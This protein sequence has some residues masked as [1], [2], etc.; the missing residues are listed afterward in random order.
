MLF[1]LLTTLLSTSPASQSFA[2]EN[3]T[4]EVGDGTTL[5]R[6]TVWVDQGRIRAVGETVQIPASV[7]RVDGRGQVLTPGLFETQTQLGLFEVEAEDSTVDHQYA[8]DHITPD[9]RAVDGFNPSN[10]R[11]PI[12]RQEGVTHVVSSPK[13]GLLFGSGF[14]FQLSGEMNSVVKEETGLFGSI[15][16]GATHGQGNSRPGLW[17][18]MRQLFDDAIFYRKHQKRVDQGQ[19]RPLALSTSKLK[20]L[21]PV[22]DGKRR[23]VLTAHRASDLIRAVEFRNAMREKGYPVQLVL[24]GGTEAWKVKETLAKEQ[25]PVILTPS[26]QMPY[27]FSMLYARDDNPALLEKAGVQ[28]VL[29]SAT[30]ANNVRRLRQEAGLAVANG[31]TREGALRAISLTPAEVFGLEQ[32]YGSI[33]PGKRANLV[34]WSADPLELGT[35]A[36]HM[37]ID[38]KPIRLN[39]RQLNLAKK[40]LGR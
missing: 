15:D 24:V 11:I 10:V 17:M 12:E 21:W 34:L 13:G 5:P 27:S 28:V 36:R 33:Q 32:D 23:L 6:A 4:I 19:T 1:L 16:I 29:S 30:W 40:Y 8:G 2:I 7:H 3:V 31:M 20:A 39:D 26:A 18:K 35:H 38:G 14:L 22:L 25:V 9:F 37:W